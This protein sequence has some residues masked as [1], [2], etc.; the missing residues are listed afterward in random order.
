MSPKAEK[1]MQD[2]IV[3]ID[4]FIDPALHDPYDFC[5]RYYT[6]FRYGRTSAD[7]EHKDNSDSRYLSKIIYN[8]TPDPLL[9]TSFRSA[10]DE[11]FYRY[12]CEKMK[13]QWTPFF[14]YDSSR[15]FEDSSKLSRGFWVFDIHMNFRS[16]AMT[17]QWHQDAAPQQEILDETAGKVPLTQMDELFVQALPK[18]NSNNRLNYLQYTCNLMIGN[19]FREDET[20]LEIEGYGKVGWKGNRMTI[21]P[22]QLKHRVYW[23][24]GFNSKEMRLTYTMFGCLIEY[25]LEKYKN[26]IRTTT[27]A[28]PVDQ[29][30]RQRKHDYKF[31]EERNKT[32]PYLFKT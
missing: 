26:N 8:G 1:Q 27:P 17:D 18:W 16:V 4:D 19:N 23:K 14:T 5:T 22:S 31:N 6:E 25:D 13:E 20:G 2:K 10:G 29:H 28:G 7:Y 11:I 24:E 15:F 12:V 9:Q 32:K 3:V 30:D 21:L